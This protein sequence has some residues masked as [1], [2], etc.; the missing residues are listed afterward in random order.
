M[1]LLSGIGKQLG[2]TV[3]LAAT[4]MPYLAAGAAPGRA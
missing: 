1:G 4:L 2:T 3:D